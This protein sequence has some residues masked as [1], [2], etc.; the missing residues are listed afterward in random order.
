MRSLARHRELIAGLL[1]RCDSVCQTRSGT[2]PR[3]KTSSA[4]ASSISFRQLLANL[5]PLLRLAT[6][7]ADGV[8]RV[9]TQHALCSRLVV[10]AATD[11]GEFVLA[12]FRPVPC[13]AL[14][15]LFQFIRLR[16]WVKRCKVAGFVRC[17][18]VAAVRN[19]RCEVAAQTV[20]GGGADAH[21][22]RSMAA[23]SSARLMLRPFLPT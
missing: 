7:H 14:G 10:G 9:D 2:A 18:G 20:E 11:S 21:T 16:C 5:C 8:V 1:S 22:F 3:N 12:L 15:L 17:E 4:V 13:F 6:L 23:L 19:K